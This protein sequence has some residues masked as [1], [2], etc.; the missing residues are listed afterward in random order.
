MSK[1]EVNVAD[2]EALLPQTQC[3]ECSYVAC[4]PYAEAIINQGERI[5][6]CAPGGAVTLQ[7][8]AKLLQQDP[9]PLLAQVEANNRPP[10]LARI[11][12]QACIG[13]TKCIRAC[14][15][16][17][18]IGSA[19]QMHTV[20]ESECTGCGLC[21]APCP[22]DCIDMLPLAKPGYVVAQAKRR[23]QAKQRRLKAGSAIATAREPHIADKQAYIKAALVRVKAKKTQVSG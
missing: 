13:C 10:Q 7:A 8:L 9:Q 19:K 17:A 11:D 15:V 20:L 23:Y 4:R 2:V 6:R 21:V 22:V 1:P 18:I 5:D 14:P 12:E 3:Q 16:D